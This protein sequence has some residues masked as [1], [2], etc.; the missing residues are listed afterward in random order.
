MRILIDS[1]ILIR[2]FDRTDPQ[3]A[4]IRQS[5]SLLR[6]RRFRA[7]TSIQN[8]AEFWN[9]CT[10]PQSA[11]GGYGVGLQLVHQRTRVIERLFKVISESTRSYRIWRRLIVQHGVQGLQ[12]HDA[13]LVSLMQS[14]RITHI[15]TLNPTD[16]ARYPGI[17]V[18]TPQDVIGSQTVP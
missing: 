12:V 1:G 11:R 3:H 5:L 13:R 16:F 2:L 6:A 4:R 18:W 14:R 8:V 7:I 9:V 17:I 10:R 15:L